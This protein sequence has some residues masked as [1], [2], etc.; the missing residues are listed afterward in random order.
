MRTEL[1]QFLAHLRN[2]R[3]LSDHTISNYQRDLLALLE[4][5]DQT[6]VKDWKDVSAHHLRSYIT[7]AFRG[8]KSGKT[9]QR[10]L[11]SIRTL[12][13]FLAREGVVRTNPAME[14]SAPK[15]KSTLP[16]TIDTDQISRLLAIEAKTWH[17]L[18]DRAIL[19]LFYSSGLRLSELVG[20][21]VQDISFDDCTIR[22]RGKGSKERLLPVGSKAI[23]ALKAWLK[24]RVL[25]P[26][27]KNID[28][29]ALFISERGARISARNVQA[30]V[31]EWCRRLGISGRVHPH[32]L[33]HSFASHM[34]ESSQDLR[35]VQELLG[36]ADIS[37]TQIYTH[38][39][40]Q[41]LADVYDKAHPRANRKRREPE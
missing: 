15:S 38:L 14:F 22:V 5:F 4:E 12:F 30:R 37:T 16:D 28:E 23:Q 33:R 13:N 21:N 17:G 31:R 18:R 7:G 2:E 20:S 27:A 10:H 32:T 40:F 24:D 1:D 25:A 35:A 41:H 6:N 11:S 19:E 34:L 39:D 3:Q 9:L 26:R 8:G 36:H 29:S